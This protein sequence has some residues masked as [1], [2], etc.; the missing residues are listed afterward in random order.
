MR[1]CNTNGTACPPIKGHLFFLNRRDSSPRRSF[2]KSHA[3]GKEAWL[4]EISFSSCLD[5]CYNP[6]MKNTLVIIRT[7]DERETL[8]FALGAVLEHGVSIFLW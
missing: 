4:G 5:N 7:C 3:P 1:I 8:P 6:F 2:S